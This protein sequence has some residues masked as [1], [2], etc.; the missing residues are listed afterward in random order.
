[1]SDE[2]I[3][4]IAHRKDVLVSR[5][6]TFAVALIAGLVVGSVTTLV[7]Q[8]STDRLNVSGGQTVEL[9]YPHPTPA[10]AHQRLTT[11]LIICRDDED[12]PDAAKRWIS[13]TSPPVAFTSPAPS[14]H[15]EISA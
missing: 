11:T 10:F 7:W 9:N 1:M 15:H 14:D 3:P 4:Y 12:A 8:R 2:R 6:L 13:R 5:R